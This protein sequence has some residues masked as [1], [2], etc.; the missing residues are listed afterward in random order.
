VIVNLFLLEF[1]GKSFIILNFIGRVMKKYNV[2]IL[3]ATGLVGQK[4]IEVLEER[5]FPVNQLLP[6]A[7]EKS[8]GKQIQFAGKEFEILTLSPKIFSGVEIAL[9]SAG[10][11]LSREIAPVAANSGAIVID[12]SK[13][14]R[15][16]P[17]VPL[18][19]PEVNSQD[20]LNQK[21]IIANP[22]CST[23]Q[24]VLALAPLHR[25][26]KIRRVVVS[27]YQA[28]S[29]SGKDAVKQLEDEIIDG[30]S[31]TPY[32]PHSIAYNCL[33]HIDKFETDGYTVEEH[34]MIRE[35][36]K[37]LNDNSIKITSTTVRVPVV[38]GHSESVN[39]EFEKEFEL[40]AIKSLLSNTPGIIVQDNP[41]KNLYP[42]PINAQDK[43]EVFVGRIRRDPTIPSGLNL[44]IV[45]DNL[46]KGAATNAVQIAEKLIELKQ[47]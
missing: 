19:V 29:G 17:E 11:D 44:W 25:E 45:S 5:Q 32:Y 40:G 47:V 9:F 22:N 1:Y 46:R 23:I 4:M 33:P 30:K 14:W 10:S 43:D 27:T 13:T 2:A 7:S 37:I 3:G 24:M 8:S 20:L 6:I 28:V 15:M 42:M 39:I 21:G 26:Y 38:S 41:K 18:V 36:H 31:N 12:N 35:T 34:K 16:D